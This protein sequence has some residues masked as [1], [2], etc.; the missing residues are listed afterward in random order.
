MANGNTIN[1][2]ANSNLTLSSLT[3]NPASGE[4]ENLMEST[5]GNMRVNIVA[6]VTGKSTFKIKTPTAISGARGTIFY[7]IVTETETR[8][9]VADGSVDF[10]NPAT[11]DTFVVVQD[12]TSLSSATGT[13]E[14][15]ELTGEDRDAVLAIYNE[16]LSSGPDGSHGVPEGE[17]KPIPQ[18]PSQTDSPETPTDN[19]PPSQ[20]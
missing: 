12:M 1:L 9:F 5:A 3:S 10:S 7:L 2:T 20:S 17:P 16:S 11:G 19:P 8:V 14:P 15:V 13:T 6:K 4:Y 18:G